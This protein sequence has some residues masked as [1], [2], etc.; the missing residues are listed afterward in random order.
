MENKKVFPGGIYG[1]AL[2]TK[3]YCK[4]KFNNFSLGKL[5]SLVSNSLQYGALKHYKTFTLINEEF[6]IN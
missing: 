4:K 3:F 1:F 2:Y 5:I 6:F